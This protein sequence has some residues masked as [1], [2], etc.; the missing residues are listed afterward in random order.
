MNLPKIR[1]LDSR[2]GTKKVEIIQNINNFN[3]FLLF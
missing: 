3:L 2:L 1:F